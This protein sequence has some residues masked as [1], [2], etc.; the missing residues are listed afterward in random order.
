MMHSYSKNNKGKINK[1]KI[2]IALVM[3][4]LVIVLIFIKFNNKTAKI[5]KFGNNMTSQEIVDYILNISSY[6]ANVTVEVTSNKNSNKYILNQKFKSPDTNSQE[7]LEPSNIAGVK[8]IKKDGNLS[9]ENTN[10]NLSTIF[11]NYNYISDN[12]LD[13]S[14]FIEEYKN[15]QTSN[16]IEEE[17]HI[18]MQTQA[19]QNNKY[20]KYKKLY[21]DKKTYM[22]IKMEIKD[23]SKKTT[24]HILYNE[25]KIGNR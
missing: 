20:T 10:L 9:L 17:N 25:V 6:E 1:T 14:S 11:E 24:V 2:I 21:I 4:I 18:I 15:E 3:L 8:I 16:Y 7:V 13:L 22:P 23:D 19:Q 12:C 5:L